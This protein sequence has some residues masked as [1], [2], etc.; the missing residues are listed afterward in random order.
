MRLLRISGPGPHCGRPYTRGWASGP[1]PVEYAAGSK[2]PLRSRNSNFRLIVPGPLAASSKG[3][4]VSARVL[5]LGARHGTGST[6]CGCARARRPLLVLPIFSGQAAGG[7]GARGPGRAA[8]QRRPP[9]RRPVV[10]VRAS[11]TSLLCKI[12][13]SQYQLEVPREQA[14]SSG[15]SEAPAVHSGT[16]P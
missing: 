2:S 9:S 1:V 16:R 10:A 13:I 5:R 8:A 6:R 14:S 15:S 12:T 3:R 4:G 7:L 11:R